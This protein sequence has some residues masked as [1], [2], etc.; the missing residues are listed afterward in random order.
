[1]AIELNLS[2]KKGYS[3]FIQNDAW[4]AF[5]DHCKKHYLAHKI[6]IIIDENVLRHHGEEV[7]KQ[8]GL[9]FEECV[10]IKIPPGEPSKSLTVWSKLVDELLESGMERTTPLLAVG[11]GVTGDLAGFVAA[12]VMRGI[13]LIHMPT[14]LLAMVDSSI[15][16]KTGVNH[17]VGK[18]LIG[19]FYQP[20]AVFCH[21]PFLKT[22]PGREWVNGLAEMLKYAAISN[23][24]LFEQLHEA[25]KS[26]FTPNKKWEQLI[27]ESAKIKSDIVETDTF[28][29]GKRAFLNFGHT[30]GHALE[31]IT[32]Y[33]TVSHGEA[34]FAGMFAA[35]HLSQHFG[36]PVE[37]ARFHPFK[38]LYNISLPGTDKINSLIEAMYS[39]K[40]VKD[41][42]LRL[43]L[44]KDW[45]EPIIR[46]VDDK[47]LLKKAWQAA[48]D[49]LRTG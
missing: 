46:N 48:F 36:A 26:G 17:T 2:F 40:K 10:F 47:R 25:V 5:I 14:S 19:A 34:V 1:M 35:V 21:L 49:G 43:I 32:G 30:F 45:G 13:P 20:E 15:G 38:A 9:F 22:L 7:K 18:N 42:K 16:G 28:E 24:E 33:T 6:F 37:M 4:K 3:V 31:N 11:G 39:D 12:S 29:A 23:P 41:H 8:C 27:Y 44:L